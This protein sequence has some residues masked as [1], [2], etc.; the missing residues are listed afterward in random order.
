MP[1][2]QGTRY[3]VVTDGSAKRIEVWNGKEWTESWQSP[4]RD[5]VEDGK[6]LD[7]PTDAKDPE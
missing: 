3:R 6:V 1:L 2:P 5:E 7:I 4:F